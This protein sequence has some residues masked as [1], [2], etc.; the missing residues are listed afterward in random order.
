VLD[1]DSQTIRVRDLSVVPQIDNKLWSV[2]STVFSKPILAAL[3]ERLVYDL[4]DQ[5]DD[6]RDR[7]QKA[8]HEFAAEHGIE[9]AL[10][11]AVVEVRAITP[12]DDGLDI[13]LGLEG[14]VDATITAASLER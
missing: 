12:G 6:A 2:L 1:A 11:E 4:K 13:L 8:L 3:E 14:S 5:T 9:L 10:H 7:L